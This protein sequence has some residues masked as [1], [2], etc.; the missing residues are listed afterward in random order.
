MHVSD[1]TQS[2]QAVCDYL[3]NSEALHF[4]TQSLLVEYR[5]DWHSPKDGTD[6]LELALLNKLST[7]RKERKLAEEW[8]R[9]Y[10]GEEAWLVAIWPTIDTGLFTLV[11]N[12]L[13]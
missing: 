5:H 8:L 13:N 10:E 1:Y 9:Y 2:R 11:N 7:K 6:P 3:A 12:Q 4:D